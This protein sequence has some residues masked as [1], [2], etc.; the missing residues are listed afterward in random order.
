M[1]VQEK[2]HCMDYFCNLIPIK[3]I[4][5]LHLLIV[6]K[7]FILLFDLCIVLK[8]SF[9]SLLILQDFLRQSLNLQGLIYLIYSF[10]FQ[11]YF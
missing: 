3:I 2:D 1:Q 10:D 11:I 6:E 9:G 7:S 4:K 8:N 5:F